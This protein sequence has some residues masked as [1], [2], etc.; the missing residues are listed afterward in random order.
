MNHDEPGLGIDRRQYY[1]SS[2]GPFQDTDNVLTFYGGGGRGA[3][4]D[5]IVALR[6]TLGR[7]LHVHGERGSGLTFLSLVLG[8]RLE[9]PCNVI[10][11]DSRDGSVAMLL[12]HLLIELCPTESTLI[13]VAAAADGVD[14]A[15]LE[16]ARERI[17]AQLA[18]APPGNKPYLLVVDLADRPGPDLIALLDA[19]GAVRRGGRYALQAVLFRVAD[20]AAVREAGSRDDDGRAADGHYWLRRLTLAE[21]GEYLRHRMML[22]DFSRRELFTREMCYFVADRSEGVFGAIDALAR[23]TFTLAGLEDADAPSMAHL[24]AAGLPPRAD[25]PLAPRFLARHRRAVVALLGVGVVGS[26]AAL[27]LLLG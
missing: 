8:D 4:V 23:R 7:T 14:E 24:L 15:T 21:V 19:L 9:R 27:V 11:H 12:R 22:F 17:L 1:A 10:R 5:D 26:F 2:R 3:V 13:D 18:E 25:A 6:H 16:R 20:A